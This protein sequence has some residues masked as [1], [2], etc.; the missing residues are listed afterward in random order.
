MEGDLITLQDL[1]RFDYAAG[2]A[3]DG[4]FLGEC[5][6]TGP[7]AAVQRSS[8]RRGRAAAPR[9]LRSRRRARR[10][11]EASGEAGGRGRRAAHAAVERERRGRGP[12]GDAIRSIS[13]ID[14]T[15]AAAISRPSSPPRPR[16]KGKALRARCGHRDRERCRSEGIRRAPARRAARGRAR[17]RHVRQ[18]EGCGARIGQGGGQRLHRPPARPCTG[19]RWCRS[20]ARRSWPARSCEDRNVAITRRAGPPGSRR[21][22]PL[23]R[24]PAGHQPVLERRRAAGARSS[25][26]PTDATRS[27]PLR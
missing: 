8:G 20:A 3:D 15:P 9:H 13:R 23:R 2:I 14:T 19:R 18:H 12:A 17:H 22:R 5:I 10:V 21:D 24:G 4:R 6:P 1:F 7:A 25:C 27:A 11:E 16:S 26:C